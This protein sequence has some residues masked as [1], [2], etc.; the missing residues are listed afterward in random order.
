MYHYRAHNRL[1]PLDV[2]MIQYIIDE[3]QIFVKAGV[4][5]LAAHGPHPAEEGLTSSLWAPT[6]LPLPTLPPLPLLW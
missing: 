6:Q 4:V 5:Q 1:R 3:S 2:S